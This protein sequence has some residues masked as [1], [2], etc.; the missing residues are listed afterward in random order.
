MKNPIRIGDGLVTAFFVG[1]IGGVAAVV[2]GALT[3]TDE[4]EAFRAWFS[5]WWIWAPLA[6]LYGMQD[7]S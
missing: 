3:G 7:Q 1:V 5:F 4:R 6:V 2:V